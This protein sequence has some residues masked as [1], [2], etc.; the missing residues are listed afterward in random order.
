[1]LAKLTQLDRERITPSAKR[2]FIINNLLAYFVDCE[3]AAD[4]IHQVV[5]ES[6]L[7]MQSLECVDTFDL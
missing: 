3:M 6:L 1:M 5:V 4:N 2:E 7:S